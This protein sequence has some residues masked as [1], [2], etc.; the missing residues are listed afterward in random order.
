MARHPELS[1]RPAQSILVAR[2][3]G[4]NRDEV[5]SYFKLLKMQPGSIFNMDETGLQTTA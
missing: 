3:E 1:I 2:T 5:A 4:M